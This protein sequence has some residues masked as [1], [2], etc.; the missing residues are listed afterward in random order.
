MCSGFFF[1]WKCTKATRAKAAKIDGICPHQDLF[2]IF[3]KSFFPRSHCNPSN[4]YC[5]L[6]QFG[7]F[8]SQCSRDYKIVMQRHLCGS[9]AACFWVSSPLSPPSP[10]RKKK[11]VKSDKQKS[12][13]PANVTAKPVVPLTTFAKL[14]RELSKWWMDT[15]AAK[16]ESLDETDCLLLSITMVQRIVHKS[17][18]W[19]QPSS[20]FSFPNQ[21]TSLYIPW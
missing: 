1:L 18:Q 13:K 14:R 2:K 17:E 19:L 12:R 3:I 9:Y 11:K 10:I 6:R 20:T 15:C 8:A 21:G 4:E 16:L 5:M 7:R